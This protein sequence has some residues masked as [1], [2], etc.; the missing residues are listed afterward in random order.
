QPNQETLIVAEVMACGPVST[1]PSRRNPSPDSGGPAL[2]SRPAAPGPTRSRCVA[3]WRLRDHPKMGVAAGSVVDNG[4]VNSCNDRSVTA[5]HP[6]G[7]C[8][9]FCVRG[10]GGVCQITW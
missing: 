6:P 2:P 4:G 9:K 5:R 3:A 7:A 1:Q 8:Q 10:E